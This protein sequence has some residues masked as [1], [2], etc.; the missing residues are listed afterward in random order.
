MKKRFV[1]GFVNTSK[2]RFATG[3]G[4]KK[5]DVNI[6]SNITKENKYKEDMS[7]DLNR[8]GSDWK[9]DPDQQEEAKVDKDRYEHK[10][11]KD[12]KIMG[13]MDKQNKDKNQDKDDTNY[14]N[15][16]VGWNS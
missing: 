2:M 7:E 6:S 10:E 4:P 13:N 3:F 15:A 8:L 16:N 5:E 12:E 14:A 9:S 1:Q 11:Q